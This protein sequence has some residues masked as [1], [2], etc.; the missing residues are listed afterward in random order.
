MNVKGSTHAL[1]A[2]LREDLRAPDLLAPEPE[3]VLI[4][5]RRAPFPVDWERAFGRLAPLHLEV[6]FG[7]GRFTVRRAL[8]EPGE[9]HV[10]LEVSNVSVQRA[11]ARVRREGVGNVRLVKVG[12]GYA[13]RQL[14]APRSLHSVT[15]NFPDPWPKERHARHR[16]LKR[17]FFDLAASR[18]APGGEV[19]LA[20]DHHE[21]LA[22]ASSE[23][24]ESGRYAIEALEPPA[25]VL[26]TKYALKWREQGK[27]LHYQVFRLERP[28]DTHPEHLERP[29]LMPHAFLN[30]TFPPASAVA[31]DAKRVHAYAGAHVI[32]HEGAQALGDA[33]R[34]LFRVTVDESELTQQVLVIAQRRGDGEVIVRLERFGDPLI[35]AAVRGAVHAVVEWLIEHAGFRLKERNY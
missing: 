28:S 32:V 9:D 26:E 33:E 23:A 27:T 24:R 22:F 11:L 4:A 6:G 20:T 2:E 5:W 30:G 1:D 15:V 29:E 8:Q 10:G 18:L 34:W 25:A 19:R 35:T 12:A 31:R 3:G 7:D 16:L 13:L 21:Y 14:F 17:E